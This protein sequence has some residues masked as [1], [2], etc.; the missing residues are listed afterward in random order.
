VFCPEQFDLFLENS[1]NMLL[2]FNL[3]PS[4]NIGILDVDHFK[5]LNDF[6]GHHA[7]DYVLQQMCKCIQTD[8]N[9]HDFLDE[10]REKNLSL[11]YQP[12]LPKMPS[13][14]LN[15]YMLRLKI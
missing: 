15:K 13:S 11:S 12:T 8:L 3:Q 14:T 6:Y 4:F 9:E 5:T 10:L 2:F 7:G 1:E